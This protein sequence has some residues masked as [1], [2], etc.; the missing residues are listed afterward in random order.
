MAPRPSRAIEVRWCL[1]PARMQDAGPFTSLERR[2]G[3]TAQRH[4]EP[5]NRW[6]G[7]DRPAPPSFGSPKTAGERPTVSP[8]CD[9]A[10]RRAVEPDHRAAADYVGAAMKT[11]SDAPVVT[12]DGSKFDPGQPI[13]PQRRAEIA[14]TLRGINRSDRTPEDRARLY[15]EWLAKRNAAGAA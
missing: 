2:C 13:S 5:S 9:G 1:L 3:T 12:R 10:D 8:D 7:K 14:E 6:P 11:W 15:E 4:D